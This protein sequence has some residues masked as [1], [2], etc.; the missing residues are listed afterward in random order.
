MTAI[1][2]G[3]HVLVTD[4]DLIRLSDTN[5]GWRFERDDDGALLVSPTSTLG[6]SQ[7]GEA[8]AQLHAFAKRA[9]GKAYDSSTGFTT[10]GGGVVCPDASWMSAEKI[11]RHAGYGFWQVMPDVAIEV[12]S[13]T[14]SWPKL[15]RK[16]DKYIEDGATYAIAIDPESG[17]TYERGQCPDGLSIDVAAISAA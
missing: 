17:D 16:I 12:K 13:Y 3:P 9:G 6:G 1:I 4:D 5:P 7:S 15:Q 10:P 8:F 14:D 2:G 11:G